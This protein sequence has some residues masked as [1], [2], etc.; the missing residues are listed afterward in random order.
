[1]MIY[2]KHG[3]VTK[4]WELKEYQF[5]M[6]LEKLK[7]S[8]LPRVEIKW[9]G[10]IS[11]FS[12]EVCS[13]FA[14]LFQ[15]NKVLLNSYKLIFFHVNA[16]YFAI[17]YYI[18]CMTGGL[19]RISIILEIMFPFVLDNWEFTSFLFAFSFRTSLAFVYEEMFALLHLYFIISICYELLRHVNVYLC[20]VLLLNRKCIFK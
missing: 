15:M 20:N 19:S 9:G 14:F 18:H 8:L 2:M 6:L 5:Q 1:M 12:A 11:T 17:S 7:L 16:Q 3:L 13:I 4:G 10:L